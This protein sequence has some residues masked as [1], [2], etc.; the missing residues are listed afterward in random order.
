MRTLA[1]IGGILLVAVAAMVP[2]EGGAHATLEDDEQLR[3]TIIGPQLP[4]DGEEVARL[5]DEGADPNAQDAFDRTAVHYAAGEH[6]GIGGTGAI[7]TLL[8]VKG[9]DCCMKDSQGDTPLHYAAAEGIDQVADYADVQGRIQRLLEH[10]ADPNEPNNRGYTALHFAAKTPAWTHGPALIESLLQAGA[11]SVAAAGDGNT[12]LHLAAGVPV[13]LDHG[14][15]HDLHSRSFLTS[16]AI[17]HSGDDSFVVRTLLARGTSPDAVNEVGLTPLLVTLTRPAVHDNP[18]VAVA[19][20]VDALLA[21]GA[22]PNAATPDD[23]TPLLL[24]LDLP[25]TLSLRAHRM[26]ETAIPLVRALLGAGADADRRNP[27]GDTPLHMAVRHEW[28]EEMAE[29]L[30]AGGAD[31]HS[32]RQREVAAGAACP[33]PRPERDRGRASACR[34]Q[35][36]RVREEKGGQARPRPRRAPA[37]PVL[38][39]GR[40][41][42]SGRA[43]RPLRAAYTGRHRRLAGRAGG[44]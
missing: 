42:R 40:G 11:D 5:L 21:S 28:G 15:G 9:G 31:P 37:H 13:I 10:G 39:Q 32:E 41:L 38:P 30:L 18:P 19:G 1:T 16:H 23:M 4:R 20:T 36:R 3:A 27:A 43:G 26:T 7:L 44:G 8:L 34:R 14:H 12:P 29:A 25:D 33:R 22:D 6:T 24:V 35:R 2:P 17:A